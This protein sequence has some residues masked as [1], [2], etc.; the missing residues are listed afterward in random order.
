VP[1][2]TTLDTAGILARTIDDLAYGF[3]ALDGAPADHAA[4]LG[5]LPRRAPRGLRLGVATG[6][7]RED[8]SP[9]V[10]EAVLE[11]A[12]RL[13]AAGARVEDRALPGVEEAKAIFDVGGPTAIELHRFITAEIPAWMDRL[14]PIVRDRLTTAGETKAGEYIRRRDALARA[15][16]AA[17]GGFEDLDVL[18]SPTVALT[19][20]KVEA[21]GA[22]D[23]YRQANLLTLRNPGLVSF[24]GLC[25]VSLPCGQDAAGMPV[26]LQLVAPAGAEARVLAVARAVE[27]V[28]R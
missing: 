10:V 24:L 12:R 27:G 1:L 26:G 19:P 22:L 2:S 7:F 16:R 8:C 3:F 18:L 15:H 17:M 13:E 9:G 14:D 25:A 5:G 28:L 6:I 21:L 11:A 20:P 4:A 23:A